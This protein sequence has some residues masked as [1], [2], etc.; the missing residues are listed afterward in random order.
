MFYPYLCYPYFTFTLLFIL[1]LAQ[2]AAKLFFP[3][4]N[5]PQILNREFVSLEGRAH[6]DFLG[7]FFESTILKEVLHKTL[8]YSLTLELRRTQK[9][10]FPPVS[11]KTVYLEW[12]KIKIW[13]CPRFKSWFC[14]SKYQFHKRREPL[15][16]QNWGFQEII[17]EFQSAHIEQSDTDSKLNCFV[18]AIKRIIIK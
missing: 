2:K 8:F 11:L 3:T 16:E 15:Q 9:K 14:S 18:I 4:L 10:Q 1:L 17:S 13:Q 12:E 7:F 5:V 6:T